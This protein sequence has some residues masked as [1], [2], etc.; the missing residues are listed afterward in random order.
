M[1]FFI[2]TIHNIKN[3]KI[4]IGKTKNL[5]NRW[6]AHKSLTKNINSNQYIHRAMRKYG[7]NNFIFSMVQEL[8]SEKEYNIAEQYW[9]CYFNSYDS[10]YGYNLTAGGDGSSGRKQSAETRQK[11]SNT[12][13]GTMVGNHNSFFGKHHSIET[14]K[15]ISKNN[16]G[17]KKSDEFRK[18]KSISML[19]ENNHFY[20]K[21]HTKE[22]L[23][24]MSGENSFSAKL[25]EQ[26]ILEIILFLKQKT[27]SQRQIS[28]IYKIS[29]AQVSRI[30][31]GKR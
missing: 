11:I 22:T 10:K 30:I 28:A 9:I 18:Q 15:N 12:K 7:F 25:S 29:Q 20:H 31:N 3:N 4:Y 23:T 8:T 27:Y 6:S 5:K 13:K 17:L 1:S 2:Y 26:Q 14:K 21:K 16:S 24:K 19:G